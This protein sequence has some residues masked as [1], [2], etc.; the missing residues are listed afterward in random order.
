[1][2]SSWTVSLIYEGM[3]LLSTFIK[4]KDKDLCKKINH[5]LENLKEDYYKYIVIDGKPAGFVVFDDSGPRPLLH[6]ND[7]QSGISYRL[8][9]YQRPIIAG[10]LTLDEATS[11]HKLINKHLKFPDGLRLMNEPV[12]YQGGIKT[13]FQ[14]AETASNFGREVGILY[15]HAHIR[16]LE[17]LAKL[18][19]KDQLLEEFLQI[20]PIGIRD[21]VKNANI[22][23]SNLYFSSSDANFYDR[24][25]AQ[26]NF[27]LLRKGKV[28]VKSGWRLYSSGPGIYINQLITN[29]F[30]IKVIN[31]N[32]YLDPVHNLDN[33]TVEFKF[34]NKLI[35]VTYY[36]NS[37]SDKVVLNN[38]EIKIAR[39]NNK[40]RK[41]L[42]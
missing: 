1:M 26:E 33:V 20:N 16:H 14:R 31:K 13:Y 30:G 38:N 18:G 35:N 3:S 5:Y 4:E 36:Q 12:K 21:V 15:V 7:K 40:Y 41:E 28:K 42:F 27:E 8:L 19:Y 24:Y 34:D 23:Q 29:Y 39:L 2:V 17:M 32:L 11:N 37:K 25:E 22:R 6:P 9:S 10:L